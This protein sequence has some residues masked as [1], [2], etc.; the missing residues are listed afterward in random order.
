VG[1]WFTEV[2]DAEVLAAWRTTL[3]VLAD[4]G[5]SVEEVALPSAHLAFAAGWTILFTEAASLHEGHLDRLDELDPG[6]VLRML[7]GR[8]VLGVDYLRALRLRTVLLDEA[9]AAFERVDVLCTIGTPGAAPRLDDLLVDIDGIGHPMQTVHS[10]AT[11]YGNVTGLPALMLPSGRNRRG[12]PLAVQLL[13]RP[14]DER[15][16]IA[17]GAAVQD[18]SDHHLA[19][20]PAIVP[21]APGDR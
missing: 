12:L 9:L 7:Q 21:G 3:A 5:A 14:F 19:R 2:C 15:T 6:F 8:L 18:R 11:I 10:R 20:P 16:L 4:A 1:G 17:C 13:G